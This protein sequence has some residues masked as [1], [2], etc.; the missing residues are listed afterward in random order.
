MRAVIL[1]IIFAGCAVG[2]MMF[3]APHTYSASD[4]LAGPAVIAAS[5]LL[6]IASGTATLQAALIGTPM[7][8]VYRTSLLT[9]QIG[10][11][12]VTIPYIGLVNILAGQEVVPEL[13]QNRMTSD[14]IAHEAIKILENADRQRVLQE[15]FQR[16]RISLGGGGASQRAAQFILAEVKA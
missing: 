12:L 7:I 11:R 9:Y 15:S 2:L 8:I 1:G 6:L 14:N 16:I 5:D 3:T 13:L 10:K 4:P